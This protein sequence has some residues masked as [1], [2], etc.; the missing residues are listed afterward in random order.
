MLRV[1]LHTCPLGAVV[2]LLVRMGEAVG[3]QRGGEKLLG[4]AVHP[5]L[6]GKRGSQSLR[7]TEALAVPLVRTPPGY[8]LLTRCAAG[9]HWV[10]LT[11]REGNRG[12]VGKKD[13]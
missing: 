10:V 5:V 3:G 11:E 2:G 9:H 4:A 8:S 12:D 6:T 13:V 1:K 7:G